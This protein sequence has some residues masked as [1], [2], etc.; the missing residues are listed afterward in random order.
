MKY[1]L[2]LNN[3]RD[4]SVISRD[5]L[6]ARSY[7]IPYPDRA[8]AEAVP[9]VRMRYESP[10]VTCLNGEWDFRFYPVP[11]EVP[12]VLD[13]DE[14]DWAVLDVPSCWQFRGYDRPFY[15]NSRYQFDFKPPK[16]PE[17][18]PVTKVFTW[19]SNGFDT[20]KGPFRTARPKEPEYNFV[21]VYRKHFTLEE[22]SGRYVIS[23]LGVSSCLD[24][25]VNGA[26][27]GYTESSFNTAE[28]DLTGFLHEGEN[29]L[30]AVVHRWCTGTYLECQDMF[31]NN[32]IFRDVL[33]Y[34]MSRTS[35]WDIQV[36]TRR[37]QN[38]APDGQGAPGG[39]GSQD[40][41][42]CRDDQTGQ[43]YILSCAAL[44]EEG[45]QIRFTLTGHGFE[46]SLCAVVKDGRAEASFRVP[47][48][49][50][51]TAE[52]PD[53]YDLY[54]ETETE[55]VRLRCGFKEVRIDGDR[56]LL[57]GKLIKIRGV[58]HHDSTPANGYAMTAEEIERDV[59]LMKE[60][61]VNTVR[62]SHYPPDP[63]L[64][65][66]CAEYGIYVIDETNLETHG[67]YFQKFPPDFD[68]ISDD[69]KWEAHYLDR[70]E[71]LWERDK[72]AP[73]VLMWSLGNESG[74]TKNTD[75]MY[76]FFK[77]RSDLP[78]H[79]EGV[80]HT[81]RTAYDVASEMYPSPAHL[82]EV[83]EG[84]CRNKKLCDRPF[85]LCEY[86][87]AMGVGPGG[88]DDYMKIF[89]S[90]EN[91]MGG[92]I[93]EMCDHAVLHED[94]S[95]TYG[96]DHGEWIHDGNFCVDGLFYPDRTPSTG[97]RMMRFAYRPLVVSYLNEGR[98]EIFNTLSFTDA[99]AYQLIF[100]ADNGTEVS[101]VP[102]TRPLARSTV[103]LPE[104]ADAVRVT[105]R[106]KEQKSGREVS[107][108][109]L[110]LREPALPVEEVLPLTEDI[111][112][113]DGA[114]CWEKEGVRISQGDPYTLLFRAPTDNDQ[115]LFPP[116]GPRYDLSRAKE[117]VVSVS[118]EN[119]RAV[120]K[121]RIS[122]K[123]CL[124]EAEDIY[125]GSPK[126]ILVTSRLHC[127]RGSG[128]LRRFGK[129]FVLDAS[130]DKVSY[131]GRNAETYPDMRDH[132]PVEEV[133]CA[134]SDMTEPNIRP[135]ES[136]NRMD[137]EYAAFSDGVRTV[138]FRAQGKP[139]P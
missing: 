65:A 115:P 126:G 138:R 26:F 13:T 23:F 1:R 32:G 109:Q 3:Y 77:S 76:E 75:K 73:A 121:S 51:W 35:L 58:N 60:Y 16:I 6:P 105:V 127:A 98:F 17:N 82:R 52:T 132:A 25:Y 135:Q 57:N 40:A 85:F 129:T 66:L 72:N 86:A 108:E 47:S 34:R 113:E 116:R 102:K 38:G 70:A 55:C 29:E 28:F 79:Y 118:R 21:G 84:R 54:L 83:G 20:R 36:K 10:L 53:L 93:W 125:E 122:C 15:L 4:H 90:Y 41:P 50:E 2:D 80:I 99:D 112:D 61:H 136:G 111:L 24:L 42:D 123:G 103:D 14:T 56:F 110:A 68:R 39:Q 133:R 104:L 27:A 8:G 74:G 134:V 46:E 71:R 30:L 31:R 88:L 44:A 63:L 95:F 69:P 137:T 107:V 67:A 33:L 49:K 94:G 43:D 22:A 97:A 48:A 117:Q 139:L 19:F 9:S 119:G 128:E 87:H 92:C 64:P 96:G 12:E 81:R 89:Y 7:F 11:G 106:T 100:S 5:R 62:T 18:D 120:V 131:K 78:V 37:D 45:C 114:F 124:L 91:I 101:V 59:K 130:F